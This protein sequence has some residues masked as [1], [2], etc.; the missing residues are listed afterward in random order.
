MRGTDTTIPTRRDLCTPTALTVNHNV[1]ECEHMNP[2]KDTA[3]SFRLPTDLKAALQRRAHAE[4]RSLA[5]YVTLVLQTHVTDTPEPMSPVGA[6]VERAMKAAS[7]SR[8][9]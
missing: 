1:C 5:Q 4:H 3:I 8:K 9:S 6:A 2:T 7:K